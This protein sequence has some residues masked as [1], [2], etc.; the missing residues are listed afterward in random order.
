MKTFNELL[1]QLQEAGY[2]VPSN[3]AKLMAKKKKKLTKKQQQLDVDKDGKIEGS[4][5]KK[6]RKEE[7]EQED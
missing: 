6:L 5:L 7:V 1:V 3:Y 4:D 2:K